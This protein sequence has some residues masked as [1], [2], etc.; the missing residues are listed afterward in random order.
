MLLI[1]KHSSRLE[2]L[3]AVSLGCRFALPL[4]NDAAP[5]GRDSKIGGIGGTR[6]ATSLAPG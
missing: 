2:V 5:L 4:Y 3:I 6:G 1:I